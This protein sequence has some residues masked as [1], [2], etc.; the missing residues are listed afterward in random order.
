MKKLSATV[1]LT[2]ALFGC[3]SDT[4]LA[5]KVETHHTGYH[6]SSSLAAFFAHEED[7]PAHY[8]GFFPLQ[9]GHDALLTRLAMIESASHSLDLQYYI[10]RDDETSQLL[11]WRLYEA[12]ERGV[13]VR[14][15]LDDMQSRKD[16]DIAYLNAHPNIEVRLFNP[17]QYRFL[18]M[19]SWV[20]DGD[21]LNRRM[22]NKSM[23]ADGVVSV[24]G[25]RN[26]GNEYFSFKSD[27]EFGDFDVLL[28]GPVVEETQVQFDEYWNSRFSAPMAWIQKS[29]RVPNSEDIEHW[30]KVSQIEHQFTSDTYN[31]DTLPLYKDIKN[32][33]VSLHWGEA[34]LLYDLPEKV[35]NG[36]SQLIDGL[37]ELLASVEHTAVIISPYFVPTKAGTK[38]LA[39]AAKQG[40]N[41][42]I[43]TNSLASND[44]FAVHGWYAK[45][46]E[47]LVAAGIELWEMKAKAKIEHQWSVT[48]S[49]RSSLHA[50]VMMLDDRKL[51][52]GSMN[53][54]PRSAELNTEMAVVFD[55]PEYVLKAKQ[56]LEG[57]L[58]TSAYKLELQNGNLVWRDFESDEVLDEEPD[59]GFLLKSGAWLSGLLPIENWL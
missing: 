9:T 11:V 22:H 44:V 42:V 13:K 25:G 37:V 28:N 2:F 29:D 48:G 12:A 52:V 1:L 18:R 23:T 17:H 34:S 4:S 41:I 43:L 58:Y 54:D 39:N 33:Q 7:V 38:A 24:V 14:L 53:M 15:L 27:V 31:F 10:F 47:E 26:I 55:H 40:K 6:A 50:K 51:F 20:T 45:Y 46:R 36:Q 59:A 49:S 56:G 30:R 16:S 35:G 21:R 57:L 32:N 5:P 8:S 3:E 19:L